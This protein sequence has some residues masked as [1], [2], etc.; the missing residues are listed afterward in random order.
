M[1]RTKISNIKIVSSTDIIEQDIIIENGII[2]DIGNLSNKKA[3][4]EIDGK[5]K[6]AFP[7]FWDIHVHLDDKIGEFEI[8]DSYKTGCEKA[9]K[10]GI[11]SICSFVT[12]KEDETLLNSI[13]KAKEKAKNSEFCDIEWHLTPTK[14]DEKSLEEI[15]K[16]ISKGFRTFKFYTTY[17]KAGIYRDYKDIESF[18]KHFANRDI[19]ILVHCEDEAI[20]EEANT[21]GNR[22][23][24]HA[25]KRPKKAEIEA[26]R[27]I[28]SICERT[29][30]PIHIVHISSIL[31]AQLLAAAKA[32]GVKISG[33]TA[34]Q[35]L[36]LN[37]N[38]YKTENGNY[39]F[40]TPPLRDDLNRNLLKKA[41]LH[42]VFDLYATDHCPFSA[43][44]KNL[45]KSDISR[46]PNGLPGIESIVPLLFN[47]YED[48]NED[49]LKEICRTFC[50]KPAKFM[51]SFPQKGKIQIGSNADIAIVSLGEKR[52][53]EL[54]QETIHPYGKI[55][56]HVSIDF[57]L[58][59]WQSNSRK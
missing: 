23:I 4:F 25:L 32:K 24:D 19:Q 22:F 18:A 49:G 31:S 56:S 1:D 39:A 21:L 51:N 57:V 10:N 17:K 58:K 8:A 2:S 43:T 54:C 16:L 35:Y 20:L 36:F 15:K 45:Y 48:R 33:E 7:G 34:M 55:A 9:I 5:G 40:C 47:L 6:Y 38:L 37:E 44:D 41:A 42:G 50:E 27:E 46:I 3:D 52:N 26:V 29:E 53:I 11:T 59:K 13:Q 30:V 28:I 12:Q 14:F